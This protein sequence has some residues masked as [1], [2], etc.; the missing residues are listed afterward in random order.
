M[1]PS[2]ASVVFGKFCQKPVPDS[3]KKDDAMESSYQREHLLRLTTVAK[4]RSSRGQVLVR[5]ELEVFANPSYKFS[6]LLP[7]FD[8]ES[9]GAGKY[10]RADV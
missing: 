10:R 1:N 6:R 7:C 5:F 4:S 8:N 3:H 9:F 2:V